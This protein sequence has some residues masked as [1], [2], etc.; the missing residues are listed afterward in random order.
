M[1]GTGFDHWGKPSRSLRLHTTGN[2]NEGEAARPSLVRDAVGKANQNHTS[3]PNKNRNPEPNYVTQPPPPFETC[4][5]GGFTGQNSTI[6][7][8]VMLTNVVVVCEVLGPMC[9]WAR[10]FWSVET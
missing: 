6:Q 5:Q 10:G 7:F 4:T 3:N 2:V 1:L 8:L 9:L